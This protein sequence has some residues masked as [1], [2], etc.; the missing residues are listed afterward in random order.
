M[1]LRTLLTLLVSALIAIFA[2][3]FWHN[4]E[5]SVETT[6]E[7]TLR[8]EWFPNSN[9]A[10]ALFA[11][12]EF[13]L[14]NGIRLTIQPG[15]DNIDPIKLVLSGE[16]NFG[17]AAADRVIAANIK[18]AEL[19]V[20]GVLNNTSPT[21]FLAREGKN[22]RTPFD[23][24]GKKIGVLTG[25]STEFVYRSLLRKTHI[26]K[27][28]FTELDIPFD[29]ATFITGAYDVRPAFIYD[30]PVSLDLKKIRY[31]IIRPSDYGVLFLGTV[32]FTTKA[33]ADKNPGLVQ[34]FINSVAQGWT[35]AIR[36]PDQGI[37]YL[38]EFDNGTDEDRELQS[39]QKSLDYFR[40]YN[41]EV[42]RVDRAAWDETVN[43]LRELGVVDRP[44]PDDTISMRFVD[45]Y[46]RH[47]K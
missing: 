45:E 23:F 24:H 27:S 35:A 43:N 37:R 40:G 44:V 1:K 30:E 16:S 3:W 22:I 5:P 42:L 20:I 19:V 33:F 31:T 36:Y 12:H 28:T 39:L 11:A 4:R 9:Y 13:A 17:D 14:R 25:T 18:G 6:T 7:V 10:G 32:Y 8:Q 46:Y 21:V 15:S 34:Q 47:T 2:W 41:G 38:K 26:D 29:L